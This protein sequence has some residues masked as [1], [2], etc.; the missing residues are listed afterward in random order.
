MNFINLLQTYLVFMTL[1]I[2]WKAGDGNVQLSSD[3]RLNFGSIDHIEYGIKIFSVPVKIFSPTNSVTGES[4]IE[5]EG[6]IGLAFIGSSINAYT[7]KEAVFEILQHLQ[8]VPGYSDLSMEG[9]AKVVFKIF[10][11]TALD[12]G[13]IM[14]ESGLAELVLAGYCPESNMYRV[15]KFTCDILPKFEEILKEPGVE[16]FGSGKNEA[17]TIFIDQGDLSPLHIIRKVIHNQNIPSVGGG[18]QAGHFEDN[19]FKIF[20]IQDYSVDDQGDFKEYLYSLR[21]I[22]LY[23][24]AFEPDID[25]FHINY[26][27]LMPFEAEINSLIEKQMMRDGQ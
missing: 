6:I 15:F 4:S 20:G 7:V 11:K 9:I 25:G 24:D 13:N 19:R 1:V 17:E 27:F 22:N 18:I 12:L 14:R 8:Y 10:N 2:A 26:T 3:S 5:Y 21:G 23:K 16:F